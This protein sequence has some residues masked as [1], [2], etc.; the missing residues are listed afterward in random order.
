MSPQCEICGKFCRSYDKG[1]LYG[2]AGSME[3][4]EPSYFCEKCT[5]KQ[6]KNPEKVI[7]NCWWIKPTFVSVAKAINRHNRKIMHGYRKR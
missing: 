4:P 1:M 3:P 5:K 2:Y 7:I 6:L